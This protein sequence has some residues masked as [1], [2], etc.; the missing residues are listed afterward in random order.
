MLGMETRGRA[1]L[2]VDYKSIDATGTH[3]NG[4]HLLGSRFDSGGA[5]RM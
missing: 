3:Q 4:K 1:G 5:M 2:L